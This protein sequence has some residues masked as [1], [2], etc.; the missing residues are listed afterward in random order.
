M[1]AD[2]MI[3]LKWV[4][5]MLDG[6]GMEWVDLAQEMDKWRAAVNFWVP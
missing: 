6:G 4:L 1:V 3:I 5:E 2:V